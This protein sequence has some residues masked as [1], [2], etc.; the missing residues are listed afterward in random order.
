[1]GRRGAVVALVIAGVG[2]I[3]VVFYAAV[4][5]PSDDTHTL[6]PEAFELSTDARQITVAY[7]GSTADQIAAQTVREDDH[8]VTVS[9]RMRQERNVFQNGTAVKV[10]FPLNAPLGSRIVQDEGGTAIVSG[11]Q[12]LCPG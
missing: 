9:V 1:M 12:Y 3:A 11:R 8:A 2:L 7:C 6:R 4:W 5:Q 10:T